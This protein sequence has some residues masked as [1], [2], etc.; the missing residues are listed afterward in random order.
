MLEIRQNLLT[1]PNFGSVCK[2]KPTT[3]CETVV[4]QLLYTTFDCEAMA[5]GR[6]HEPAA[7]QEVASTQNK[8][9]NLC[10]WFI[11]AE[12][13]F[14]GASPDGLIDNDGL[15]VIKYP[16]SAKNMTPNKAILNRKCTLWKKTKYGTFGELNF[17]HDFYNHIQGQLHVNKRKYCQFV[18]LTPKGM[19]M[20]RI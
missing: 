7:R 20:Q 13:P 4:K 16:S 3:G 11:D 1:A 17:N 18:L 10:G 15:V 8:K 6:Q 5:C 14:L 2:I 12:K 9:I 19:K